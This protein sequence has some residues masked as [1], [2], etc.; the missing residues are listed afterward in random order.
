M[1]LDTIELVMAIEERFG[2]TLSD[3]EMGHVTTPGQLVDLVFS[4]VQRADSAGY[5]TRHAFYAL[6][7][8]LM[9]QGQWHRSQ[10]VPA[11]RLEELVPRAGRRKAWLELKESLSAGSWPELKR[12]PWLVVLLGAGFILMLLVAIK[13]HFDGVSYWLSFP[14]VFLAMAAALYLTRPL[15]LEF[16]AEQATVGQLSEFLVRAAPDLFGPEGRR[17]ARPDVAAVIRSIT[18]EELGLKPGQ[19]R[20]DAGF[21]QD[22]GAG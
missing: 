21:V 3:A 5:L 10:I 22:L 19:Y 4:K 11:A 2:I 17:W 14:A 18:I 20:E 15:C 1:G 8:A 9:K 12:P 13:L 6:R 16:P 7:R